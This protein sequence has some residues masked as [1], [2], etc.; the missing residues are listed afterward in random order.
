M[1]KPLLFYCHLE[2]QSELKCFYR[3]TNANVHTPVS[4]DFNTDQ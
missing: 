3:L 1:N 2:S 4:M